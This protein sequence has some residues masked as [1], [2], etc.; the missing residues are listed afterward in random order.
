M[1][2]MFP[3]PEG[4][5]K[6]SN[7]LEFWEWFKGIVNAETF[8]GE[9]VRIFDEL[10]KIKFESKESRN[11]E[12]FAE[13]TLLVLSIRYNKKP[14]YDIWEMSVKIIEILAISSEFEIGIKEAI[15]KIKRRKEKGELSGESVENS[16]EGSSSEKSSPKENN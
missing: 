3:I 13:L 8:T 15:A 14:K 6:N 2:K 5:S 1:S 4:I 10:K 16:L 9:T 7:F 12:N 11:S